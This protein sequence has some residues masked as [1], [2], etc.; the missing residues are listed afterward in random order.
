M[1]VVAVLLCLSF[2]LSAFAQNYDFGKVSKEELEEKFNPL[3]SSANA[4]YLY[5]YRRTYFE[6]SEQEGFE[7]ITEIHERVKIYHQDGF[8]YATKPIRLYKSRSSKEEAHNI[9]AYT[10]NLIDGKVEDTKLDKKDIFRTE[11]SKYRDE[12][13]FTMPNIKE[14]S[15]IEYK[16]KVYS[17]FYSNID[18]F[19]FQNDIPIKKLNAKFE[20][21][22]YFKFKLNARGFL[23]ITPKKENRNDRFM[24][25]STKIDFTKECYE[26]NLTNIPALKEEPHVNSINN[27]R[28]AISYE[29]SYTNFPQS[30][31]K[32]YSTTWEDV[33][34]NI[35]ESSNFGGE[36]DKEGYYEDDIDALI[37]TVSNPEKRVALI[38]EYVKSKIKWNGYYGYY[39]SDGVKTA[40]KEQVGNVAEINLMLTSMLRYAGI[41][42]YPV[43]VSTRRN[44]VP[45]FPTREGYNYVITYVKYADTV[46]L[47]DATSKY[48]MPNVLPFRA[49]NW[50][51]RIITDHGSSA[52]IDLYPKNI[53]KNTVSL[54]AKLDETGTIEGQMRA[55]KT[56]HKARTYRNS[57]NN[58]DE[59]KFIENLENKYDGIEVAEFSVKN[60]TELDKPVMENCKFTMESQADIINDKIYFSP[61]FFFR[62]NE[63]P[64]KLE[65]REFPVDFGYPSDDIYRFNITL[66]EGYKIA[67]A[68][69]SKMLKLPDNLGSFSYQIKAIGNTVQLVVDSKINVPIVS[70]IYYDALKSYFS[71]LIEAENE[72]I[73]LTR[74]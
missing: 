9:K 21:P 22:E 61:L 27:Y 7:L 43:L 49:L 13:K 8:K 48:S 59:D 4:A 14:G 57:Y 39:T 12:T 45:L 2:S 64:F 66:P 62:T 67:S 11:K 18:D 35:Y 16:Y 31:V 33:V 71:D 73:V 72:Q 37:S 42:A 58:E 52:L 74:K 3:D 60:N 51:G 41:K 40:Y 17:P 54:F 46:L 29:L 32:Y 63:S 70:P 15:V 34:K 56:G 1:K 26:Y 65:S 69:Q 47:L 30:P 20:A 5:K 36:L 19:V 23:P 53:S 68:P 55:V 38:F 44:G 6:Y 25:G 24:I 28:S 10:Y 50:Q